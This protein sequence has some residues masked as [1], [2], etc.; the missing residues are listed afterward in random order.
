MQTW[1]ILINV[2]G[3][4]PVL[5]AGIYVGNSKPHDPNSYFEEFVKELKELIEEGTDFHDRIL[6]VKVR[7]FIFD[8]PARAFILGVKHHSGFYSCNQCVQREDVRK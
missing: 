5:V 4:T 7:A 8:A 6:Q 1:P 3:T 2:N